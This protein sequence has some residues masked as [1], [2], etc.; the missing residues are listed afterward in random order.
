MSVRLFSRRGL[1]AIA[2]STLAVLAVLATGCGTTTDSTHAG[3]S[4]SSLPST[5]AGSS[6][7]GMPGMNEPMPSGDGLSAAASGFT[8]APATTTLPAG[9]AQTFTFRITTAAGQNVTHFVPEQTQLLHFYLIRSDLTGFAHLHPSMSAE[10]V[11]SVELPALSPGTWRAYTQFITPNQAGQPVSLVLSVPLSV[12][13]QAST[14]PLPAPSATTSV[15]GYALTLSG[16]LISGQERELTLTIS[17]DG[18]PVTDLQ[19]Y[20]DTY[21]HLTAIHAGDLAFA[22]LHPQGSVHGDHGGPTLTFHVVFPTPGDW[23][24]FIQF[25]TSGTL[26]TAAITVHVS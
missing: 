13:G 25:Q 19:P 7:P 22:H 4:T 15:D 3:G 9:T 20:L 23:R 10:G 26:H 5:S 14:V 11:W 1:T 16:Q 8:L 12:A 18:T 2:A 17:R 6:M 24:L 21:A